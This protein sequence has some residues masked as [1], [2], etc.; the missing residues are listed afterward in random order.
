M[1][2]AVL[3]SSSAPQSRKL[4]LSGNFE[5]ITFMIPFILGKALLLPLLLH[6]LFEYA[7]HLLLLSLES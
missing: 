3:Q 2:I 4:N 1:P 6:H 7:L 5:A